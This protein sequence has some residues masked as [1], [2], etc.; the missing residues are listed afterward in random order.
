MTG[1]DLKTD[2]KPKINPFLKISWIAGAVTFALMVAAFVCLNYKICAAGILVLPFIIYLFATPSL[3]M[4][5]CGILFPSIANK[6]TVNIIASLV[7]AVI[8][9]LLSLLLCIGIII[10]KRM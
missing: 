10:A 8:Y 9:L 3:F 6:E 1:T 2:N 5:S 4:L 7:S